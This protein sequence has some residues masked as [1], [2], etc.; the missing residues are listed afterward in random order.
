MSSAVRGAIAVCLAL[1]A[2]WPA[3]AADRDVAELFDPALLSRAICGRAPDA[4][5]Q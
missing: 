4:A 5:G 2:A 1:L 3:A